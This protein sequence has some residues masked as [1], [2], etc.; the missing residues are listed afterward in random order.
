MNRIERNPSDN[1]FYLIYEVVKQKIGWTQGHQATIIEV[2]DQLLKGELV[3]QN[4][5]LIGKIWGLLM[6]ANAGIIDRIQQLEQEIKGSE[7]EK[8]V[9]INYCLFIIRMLYIPI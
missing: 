6:K 1:Y 2:L 4:K 5:V 9:I 7:I 3:Y 8:Q